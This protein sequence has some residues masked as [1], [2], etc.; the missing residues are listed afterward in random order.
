MK[1]YL[2]LSL[3]LLTVGIA[4]SQSVRV[5]ITDNNGPYTGYYE[6]SLY[7]QDVV[8]G[9]NPTLVAYKK[10]QIPP[11]VDFEEGTIN[12]LPVGIIADQNDRYRYTAI[13]KRQSGT[14]FYGWGST[15]LLDSGEVVFAYLLPIYVTF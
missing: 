15:G 4:K 6:V 9:T 2:I 3:I 10:N 1:K 5:Y 8:L 14:A 13:V 12:L 7:V 11:Y